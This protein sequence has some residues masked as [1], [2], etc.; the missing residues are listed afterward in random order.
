MLNF[1]VGP[2]HSTESVRAIGAQDV[3][4]F[5]TPE[6]SEVM[7]ENERLMKKFAKAADDAR[8]LFITGSGSAS[9]EASVMNVFTKDDH[10]LVINGGSFGHRFVEICQ[11]HDI[12]YTEIVPAFGKGVTSEDLAPF[13]GDSRY[14]GLLVNVDE[15]SMGILY[16]LD[17]LSA[18]CQ[19]NDLIFVVD[20]ISSFLCDP[21]HMADAHIDVLLTGSQKALACPPG[22]SIMVLSKRAVDRIYAHEVKSLY[23]NLQSALDNGARGQTPFTPA[24]GILLQIHQ[25]L[26]DIEK[27]GGVEAEIERVAHQAEDFRSKIK[28][29]PFEVVSGS[30]PNA[31][32]PL[33]PTTIKA[34]DLFQILKD[35]YHIWVCPNGG[36][37]A[38]KIFRV[39]HI[40]NLTPADNDTLIAA[41]NDLKKRGLI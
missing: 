33:M 38:E 26:L 6:F 37:Y 9:M 25:R 28:G 32:T 12:P 15:T 10:L 14:T 39:G 3:P 34:T 41:F 36:E 40:G 16:D 23:F 21:I 17:L 20:A 11:I 31:V 18:F 22:V 7:L 2:V 24:V 1:T 19:K 35:E 4:Y 8:A 13:D 27:A 30:L 5:R 29:L